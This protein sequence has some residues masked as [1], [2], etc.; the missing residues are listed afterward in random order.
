MG[1]RDKYKVHPATDVFPMMSDDELKALGEDI[2]ARGLREPI[3]LM[4]VSRAKQ[5]GENTFVQETTLLD[6]RNRLEAMERVGIDIE[7]CAL[8]Y[9]FVNG[10]RGP[11]DLDAVA[12]IISLNIH[13]RHLTKHQQADLIVAAHAAAPVVSR[14]DGGK[15]SEGRPVNQTKAAAVATAKEHGISKRTVERAIA[16]AEGKT[17]KPKA[18]PKVDS[19]KRVA[20]QLMDDMI[21]SCIANAE[22]YEPV[23]DLEIFWDRASPPVSLALSL[24]EMMDAQQ[25]R[26]LLVGVEEYQS[27]LA[28]KK[29]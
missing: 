21:Q 18:K 25:V 17:P 5:I 8:K 20:D 27:Q 26:R 9:Q 4:Y 19:G 12:H 2:L 6:G 7:S 22:G 29:K 10:S 23:S 28:R 16:K 13:R 11:F 3:K 14:Q 24:V 1:W 15:L